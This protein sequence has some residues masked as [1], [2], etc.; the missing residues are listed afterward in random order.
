[1]K[2]FQLQTFHS[3]GKE[4]LHSNYI[5]VLKNTYTTI[6]SIKLFLKQSE[7][8]ESIQLPRFLLC[9]EIGNPLLQKSDI[10]YL[11]KNLSF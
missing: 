2:V 7:A 4:V 10:I 6:L 11:L 1:M 8:T 9:I 3:C 5:I